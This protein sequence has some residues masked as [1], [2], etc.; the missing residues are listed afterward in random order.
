MSAKK[1]LFLLLMPCWFTLQAQPILPQVSGIVQDEGGAPLL[2]ITIMLRRP[3][4][5]YYAQT[6]ANGEFQFNSA[7]YGRPYAIEVSG[8]GYESQTLPNYELKPG[9]LIT[10]SIKLKRSANMLQ[11][12]VIMGYGRALKKDITSSIT[13]LS[14]D[15]LNK[16]VITS[17]A[18]LLQGKVA[19]LNI[20]EDGNPTG[21]PSIILRGP[22]TLNLGQQPFYVIDDVP[23][24]DISL[25]SPDDIMSIEVLKDASATAI[26][27]NRAANGVI[28]I[29]TRRGKAGDLKTVY[30]GYAAVQQISNYI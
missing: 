9:T 20:S 8:L 27:G 13:L 6:N 7:A 1:W 17:A 3:A 26:Y 14:N 5:T 25:I 4:K 18:Q 22:S 19:G 2:G 12:V 11:P 29:A 30:N 16:G 24:A 21:V 15:D 28:F 10:L 23:D